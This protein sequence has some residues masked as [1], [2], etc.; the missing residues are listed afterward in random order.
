MTSGKE[1]DLWFHNIFR[2]DGT[3]FSEDEIKTIKSLTG[4]ID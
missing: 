4:K 1:P 2:I 3:P